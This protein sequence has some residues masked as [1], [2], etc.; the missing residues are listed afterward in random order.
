[1]LT[2]AGQGAP[3]ITNETIVR[4]SGEKPWSELIHRAI[5]HPTED[6]H[7]QKCIRSLIWAQKITQ[8]QKPDPDAL[9]RDGM[10]LK[11]AN[12]STFAHSMTRKGDSVYFPTMVH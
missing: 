11:L 12:M 10:W 7:L 2:Y 6:G 4:Y 1:M 3:R 8:S 9:L 5:H